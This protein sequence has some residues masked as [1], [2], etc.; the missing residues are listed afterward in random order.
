MVNSFPGMQIN[1]CSSKSCMTLH[2]ILGTSISIK[3]L[4]EKQVFLYSM[5]CLVSRAVLDDSLEVKSESYNSWI[6]F[7]WQ[8]GFCSAA[9]DMQKNWPQDL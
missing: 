8:S 9:L 6:G 7:E 3:S 4:S 5:H 2:S 1:V